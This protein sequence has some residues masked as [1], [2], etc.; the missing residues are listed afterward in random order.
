MK[1]V[2]TVRYELNL[3]I[4][5][6]LNTVL[7]RL[8]CACSLF[9]TLMHSLYGDLVPTSQ[10]RQWASVRNTNWWMLRGEINLIYCKTH[11]GHPPPHT[12]LLCHGNPSVPRHP[13][14]W[15]FEITL[16]LATLGGNPLDEWSA[17]RRDLNLTTHHNTHNGQRQPCPRR[18][19]NPKSQQA[20][21][22]RPTL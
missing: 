5:V 8:W 14:S 3:S 12:H 22:R 6:T 20:S 10:R 19:S 1:T 17:R 2:F 21:G 4:L 11:I 15:D 16:R 9:Y 13:H 7:I 18:N